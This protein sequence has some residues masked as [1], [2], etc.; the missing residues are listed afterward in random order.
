MIVRNEPSIES[1]ESVSS[2]VKPLQKWHILKRAEVQL[3]D[4]IVFQENPTH[5]KKAIEG[6]FIDFFNRIIRQSELKNTSR[7]NECIWL[8]P[9]Q[10]TSPNVDRINA[11][12]C[13]K[14]LSNDERNIGESDL[15][16]PDIIIAMPVKMLTADNEV[17]LL[18]IDNGHSH[19]LTCVLIANEHEIAI[20]IRNLSF[21]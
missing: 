20:D 19:Q 4:L 5:F 6:I 12:K 16:S 7:V 17:R 10:P 3:A 11:G 21:C 1:L 9:P 8:N 15:K 13:C 14:K 2:A 18:I